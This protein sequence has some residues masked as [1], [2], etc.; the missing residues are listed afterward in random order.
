MN[1]PLTG[2][3]V[4]EFLVLI[5]TGGIES[6]I[7]SFLATLGLVT[8]GVYCIWLFNRLCMGQN[9]NKNKIMEYK[10]LDKREEFVLIIF[11]IF[12][13]L[14]GIF[15]N[16]IINSLETNIYFMFWGKNMF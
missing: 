7:I 3:F 2:G 16:G 13:F 8:N 4:S 1:L 11:I 6:K 12:I 14:M 5:G 10:D 9:I 15:P